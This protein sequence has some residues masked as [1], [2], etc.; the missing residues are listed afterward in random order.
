MDFIHIFRFDEMDERGRGGECDGNKE[1]GKQ[2]K[3]L[4]L[5]TE[6]N[7]A[8]E[9]WWHPVNVG[10]NLG[11]WVSEAVQAHS[12]HFATAYNLVSSSSQSPTFVIFLFGVPLAAAA[13]HRTWQNKYVYF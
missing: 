9:R 7:K 11:L 13:L 12:S 6:T 10:T 4:S 3:I 8:A 1:V 2:E 5:E